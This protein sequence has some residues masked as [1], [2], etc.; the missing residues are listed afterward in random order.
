VCKRLADINANYQGWDR[1]KTTSCICDNGYTNVDCSQRV[2][3]K[4]DDPITRNTDQFC[5]AQVRYGTTAAAA[6]VTGCAGYT[7]QATCTA[8]ALT[9]GVAT[10]GGSDTCGWEYK[11][12]AEIMNIGHL[13][14][15]SAG[16]VAIEYTDEFGEHWTTRTLDLA[17]ATIAADLES[18]LEALPNKVIED[19]TVTKHDIAAT[20]QVVA[21]TGS[22]AGAG[23]GT[24]T[25][26][27]GPKILSITFGTNSGDLTQLNARYSITGVALANG[28]ICLPATG[29]TE[30]L[31]NCAATTTETA[32]VAVAASPNHCVWGASTGYA[33]TG[34]HGTTGSFTELVHCDSNAGTQDTAENCAATHADGAFGPTGTATQAAFGVD[35]WKKATLANKWHVKLSKTPVLFITNARK[36]TQEN[37]VC[38]NR[39]LCD[40]ATGICKC[41][42]GYTDDDCSKQNALAMY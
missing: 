18:A 11:Q 25:G 34:T 33:V 30:T 2:C 3:P 24:F 35:F 37:D 38:S 1:Q 9:N 5:A 4:G 28:G 14:T 21:V 29:S 6:H 39:G 20:V 16:N 26:S 17:S 15:L 8:A 7:T 41:F 10:V 40:Y 32:C 27:I 42:N 22:A 36:G 19:V 12:E 31:A 13:H 23:Q